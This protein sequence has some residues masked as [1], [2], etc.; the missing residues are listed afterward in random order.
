MKEKDKAE[1]EQDIQDVNSCAVGLK[2]AIVNVKNAWNVD[3]FDSIIEYLK[4]SKR[5]DAE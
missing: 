1:M 5:C 3:M 4:E 2:N